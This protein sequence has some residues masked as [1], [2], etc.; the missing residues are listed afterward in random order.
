MQK[1]PEDMKINVEAMKSRLKER[2]TIAPRFRLYVTNEQASDL[3]QAAYAA[4][5]EVRHGKLVLDEH[6]AQHIGQAADA[7]TGGDKFGIVVNG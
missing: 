6:T 2:K 3:I 7:L 4:E 5:V 1:I